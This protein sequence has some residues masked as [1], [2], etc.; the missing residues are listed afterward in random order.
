MNNALRFY[1]Q[2]FITIIALSSLFFCSQ[3]HPMKTTKKTA[4]HLMH[5]GQQ[6]VSYNQ[7]NGSISAIITMSKAIEQITEQKEKNTFN[8]LP[9]LPAEISK[10]IILQEKYQYPWDNFK[11][12]MELTSVCKA[13]QQMIG[14]KKSITQLLNIPPVHFAAMTNNYKKIIRLQQKGYSLLEPD[15]NN[16]CPIHYAVANNQEDAIRILYIGSANPF[17]IKKLTQVTPLNKKNIAS[18][19]YQL[20]HPRKKNTISTSTFNSL[21]DTIHDNKFKKAVEILCSHDKGIA[22]ITLLRLH[23]NDFNENKTYALVLFCIQSLLEK[24]LRN[25][26]RNLWYADYDLCLNDEFLAHFTQ[27]NANPNTYNEKGHAPL[28]T[29]CMSRTPRYYKVLKQLLNLKNIDINIQTI[30]D[31]LTPLHCATHHC[32]SNIVKLL[33]EHGA[34]PTLTTINGETAL[35]LAKKYK[36]LEI[37]KLVKKYDNIELAKNYVPSLEEH[38]EEKLAEYEEIIRVLDYNIAVTQEKYYKHKM[39]IS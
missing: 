9:Q 28:H 37:S 38:F 7:R 1:I 6:L 14:T 31:K 4:K 29:V 3:L 10:N 22:G 30:S 8:L 35:D 34:D 5:C 13:W 12:I 33:L 21:E 26:T 23:D 20:D 19:L 17:T 32:H 18:L 15:I 24:K 25:E 39:E 2:F 11:R 16:L 27:F 36:D